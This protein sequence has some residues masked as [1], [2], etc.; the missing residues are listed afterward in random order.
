M[1]CS[2]SSALESSRASPTPLRA[3][4]PTSSSRSST[5]SACAT[6]RFIDVLKTLRKL[7]LDSTQPIEVRGVEVAPRDVVA[8]AL[9]DPATLG[10]RMRGLTC[11]GTFIAGHR[12]RWAAPTDVPLPRPRQRARDA[13]VGAPGGRPADRAESGSCARAARDGEWY[14]VGVLGPEAFPPGRSST[15][16]ASTARRTGSRIVRFPDVRRPR[17]SSDAR[18]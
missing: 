6:P 12:H 18:A 14:G 2:P 1:G 13:G 3:M 16:S 15:C 7:G 9:P 4:R 5:R 8:A 11:A 10:N 17:S